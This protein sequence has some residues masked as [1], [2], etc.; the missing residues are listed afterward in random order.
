MALY[1]LS[2]ITAALPAQFMSNIARQFNRQCVLL[3]RLPKKPGMGKNVT[4]DVRFSR[5]TDA[6]TFTDGADMTAGEYQTDTD[7]PATLPWGFYRV[8]FQLSGLALAVAASSKNAPEELVNLFQGQ[9]EDALTDLAKIVN[10]AAY[11]GNGTSPAIAGLYG[12]GLLAATGTYAGIARGTYSEWAAYLDS[13]S[14]TARPLSKALL[15]KCERSV[16]VAS[17]RMPNLI[18]ASAGVATKLEGLVD[19]N[20][21]FQP[22]DRASIQVATPDYATGFTGLSYKGIPIYRDKDAPVG[23][24]A[25]L[26][27]DTTEIRVLSEVNPDYADTASADTKG[28]T[29]T[30]KADLGL[31]VKILPIA[32]TGDAVKFML[33]TRLQVVGKRPNT[34]GAIVDIDET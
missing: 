13:N 17:G 11:N 31:P 27:T 19:Q 3:G 12:G 20:V 15:D 34:L 26:N 28:L 23:K 2:A 7:V 8:G 21:R 9:V 10:Q 29:D 14:G 33:L 30:N 16:F 25:M 32:R 5:G 1:D 22:G 18:V 4:W 6:A 24:L